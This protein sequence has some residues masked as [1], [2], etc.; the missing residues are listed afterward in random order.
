MN[1]RTEEHDQMQHCEHY[2]S[3]QCDCSTACSLNRDSNDSLREHLK[4]SSEFQR[5]TD[6]IYTL[7][8][9]KMAFEAGCDH[10]YIKHVGSRKRIAE[11]TF[12]EWIKK[13]KP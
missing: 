9:L 7:L 3:S 5:N 12:E 13:R 4:K 1:N 11:T 8:D 2:Q 10:E 6:R